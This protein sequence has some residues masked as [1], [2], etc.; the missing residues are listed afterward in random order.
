MTGFG[1]TLVSK[2]CH[3]YLGSHVRGR[4]EGGRAE[5]GLLYLVFYG[6]RKL[7]IIFSLQICIDFIYINYRL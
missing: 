5:G 1:D 2:T 6:N 4:A 7:I 3:F